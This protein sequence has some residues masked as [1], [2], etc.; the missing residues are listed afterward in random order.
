MINNGFP[1]FKI[2][3]MSNLS[4]KADATYIFI[5]DD[6]YRKDAIA[7]VRFKDHDFLITLELIGGQTIPIPGNET[8]FKS[9]KDKML[10]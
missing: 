8:D 10:S 5:N 9:L 7:A 1:Q 3:N 6:M 2:K 4:I